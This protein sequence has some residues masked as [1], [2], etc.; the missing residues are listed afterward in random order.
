MHLFCIKKFVIPGSASYH[1]DLF[2]HDTSA[3]GKAKK[4]V[5]AQQLWF[6]ILKSQIET[7]TPYMLFKVIY[8]LKSDSQP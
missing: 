5:Q 2:T 8:L 1:W 4:V 6:E 7:G 3:Q